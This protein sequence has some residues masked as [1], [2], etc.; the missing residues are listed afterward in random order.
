MEIKEIKF[1]YRKIKQELK[2]EKGKLPSHCYFLS[3]EDVL[4][5]PNP[6]GDARHPYTNDGLT[7]WAYSSGYITI[8]ETN[9]YIIPMTLEG[10]EPYL[11]FFGG[12]LNKKGLYD[13][14]SITGVSDTE[15]GKEK[16]EKY[17]VFTPTSVIYLRVINKIVF[18][19]E[20][21]INDKKEIIVNMN[22]INLSNRP[23]DLYLSSFVN[24]LLC[25]TNYESEE[26]KWFR[27][28]TIHED[29]ATIY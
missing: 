15:F 27:K 21:T 6:Y 29:G 25:H 4:A 20:M 2:L 13:F 17:T 5:L 9:F 8:N 24:P 16:V 1:L 26:T 10:K 3:K 22:A 14:F 28:S 19:L 18:S 23:V 11:S 7:L 12:L